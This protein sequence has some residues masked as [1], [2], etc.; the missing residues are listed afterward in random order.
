MLVAVGVELEFSNSRPLRRVAGDYDTTT[1]GVPIGE[2]LPFRYCM[3]PSVELAILRE[4]IEIDVAAILD[5]VSEADAFDATELVRVREFSI[6]LDPHLAP[7]GAASL[8][9]EIIATELLAK[10]LRTPPPTLRQNR[11]PHKANADPAREVRHLPI[12]KPRIINKT[13]ERHVHAPSPKTNAQTD[14]VA[15]RPVGGA[16]Q[17]GSEPET[18][19]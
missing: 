11:R 3:T 12:P 2:L 14:R 17:Q 7:L 4:Q 6:A 15:F 10:P 16:D 18:T 1:F 19:P 5:Q 9:V 8:P 13:G